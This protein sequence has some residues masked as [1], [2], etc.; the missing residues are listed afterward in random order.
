MKKDHLVVIT[1][2]TGVGVYETPENQEVKEIAQ[3]LCN[4]FDCKSYTIEFFPVTDVKE[5]EIVIVLEPR[6]YT[7]YWL[8]NT[9]GVQYHHVA[10]KDGKMVWNRGCPSLLML[11][12]EPTP[13]VF[14]NDSRFDKE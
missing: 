7:F 14:R 2:R 4:R 1:S 8:M 10:W 3:I 11:A 12:E 13:H 9:K 5:G 6:D